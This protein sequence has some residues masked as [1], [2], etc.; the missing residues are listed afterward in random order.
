MLH[1]SRHQLFSIAVAT[2]R[3]RARHGHGRAGGTGCG[4]PSRSFRS[5][6]LARHRRRGSRRAP[7]ALLRRGRGGLRRTGAG[8]ARRRLPRVAMGCPRQVTE[9]G[10]WVRRHEPHRCNAAGH[11]PSQ[12]R[13]TCHSACRFGS[14]AHPRRAAALTGPPSLDLHASGPAN[15][16][17]GA[18]LLASYQRAARAADRR[19]RPAI[20]QW[21][22]AIRRYSGSASPID[23]ATFARRV[24]TVIKTG[25]PAPP[26]TAST[27][28]SPRC[29]PCT[30]PAAPPA[31]GAPVDCPP[32][33]GCES[34]P[35]PYEQYGTAATDYG[36]HDLADRP[37]RPARSTT[38]S[39]TTPRATWDHAL[40][41]VQD[42][43]YLAWHYTMRSVRRPHR[44]AHRPKDVG[45]HAGNWYVN[46]HSIGIEHEGF[47]AQGATWYTES[48]YESSAALVRT[49][50]TSTA[51][52]STGRTSSATTRCRASLPADVAGMHWDPGPYWDW[53]HYFDA[54][55]APARAGD[56]HARGRRR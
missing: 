45:W 25:R 17:G 30:S 8:A 42:P 18:A 51:S 34:V 6:V 27:S 52:R 2:L 32:D 5:G 11:E 56:R 55:R 40:Q 13:R 53:E 26:T 29:R 54:A 12:G 3:A 47:A 48:M 39:S 22:G 16:C 21:Y 9:H 15:I 23:S 28:R 33:L 44:A 7:A 37:P 19:V 43:T 36:N 20:G 1:P 38:S 46:M 41:L 14:A 35:A 24:L 50:P 49:S 10:W 4:R 31:S